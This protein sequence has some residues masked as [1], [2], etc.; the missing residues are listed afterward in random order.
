MKKREDAALFDACSEL[1]PRMRR[2][3]KKEDKAHLLRA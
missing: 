3:L 2:V 1:P